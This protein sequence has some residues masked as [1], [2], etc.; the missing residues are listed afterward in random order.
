MLRGMAWIS[1]RSAAASIKGAAPAPPNPN[2]SLLWWCVALGGVCWLVGFAWYGGALA[3]LSDDWPY[4]IRKPE[5]RKIIGNL[6]EFRSYFWRPLFY[7]WQRVAVTG[8]SEHPRVL[9]ILTAALHAMTCVTLFWVARRLKLSVLGSAVAALLALTCPIGWE[10]PFWPTAVPTGLGCGLMLILIMA[11]AQVGHSTAGGFRWAI[12]VACCGLMAFAIPC[13]NEQPAAGILAIPIAAMA[14]DRKPFS[15]RLL[16]VWVV[17]LAA[18]AAY[19]VLYWAYGVG[20]RGKPDNIIRFGE[21]Y[22]RLERLA[23]QMRTFLFMNGFRRGAAETGWTLIQGSAQGWAAVV[24][25]AVCAAVIVRRS[26]VHRLEPGPSRAEVAR[27]VFLG[28][29]LFLFSWLPIA[30]VKDQGVEPRIT[31][32]GVLG[33]ALMLGGCVDAK[34]LRTPQA[35]RG[36][37]RGVLVCG[38]LVACGLGT[39]ITLGIQHAW[40]VRAKLDAAE[41]G[42]LLK[43]VPN[44]RPGSIIVPLR[45]DTQTT[46]TRSNRFDVYLRGP[47]EYEWSATAFVRREYRRS[48]VRAVY[49]NT[50][51]KV[52]ADA[53]PRGLVWPSPQS[54]SPWSLFPGM[55][56]GENGSVVLRWEWVIPIVIDAQ[57]TVLPVDRVIVER[58]DAVP[59]VYSV[60]QV[61]LLHAQGTPT[62]TVILG[63]PQD[64]QGSGVVPFEPSP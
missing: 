16:I 9:H 25:M 12:M 23:G 26:M 52:I 14:N 34:V 31:Y 44:P 48:D 20:E 61:A 63:R 6:I 53:E 33:V 1:R 18:V 64:P 41:A 22:E 11:G 4:I 50:Y 55:P 39:V 40:H 47:L 43:A 15:R 37:M 42:T 2:R 59:E 17:C 36:V 62:V 19:V 45:V 57:G 5:T 35:S 56:K 3:I 49:L 32:M 30:V 51:P 29:A 8:L 28:C 7:I 58:P 60:P 10:V 13:L 38:L 24:G 27:A 54:Q 21:V 46:R